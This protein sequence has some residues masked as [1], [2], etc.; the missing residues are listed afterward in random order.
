MLIM[1]LAT[2][3]PNN[4][5]DVDARRDGKSV[6]PIIFT[7]FSVVTISLGRACSTLPPF[8]AAK[9]TQTEPG[10]ITL[11]I[12]S[13]TRIGAFLPGIRAV[14]TMMSTSWACS[15]ISAA[16]A[17][18]KSSDISL[19]YPP[20]PLPSSLIGTSRNV[21]PMDSTCS[22]VTG[23][24][25]KA[26]TIAPIFFAVWMAASPATPAPSTS[27]FAGGTFPAAVICPAKNLGN[28]SAASMIA[29]YPAILACDERTSYV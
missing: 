24:T 28:S 18:L 9:S 2:L 21:A 14:V 7:P 16:C 5:L 12:S 1:N 17:F 6:Y 26:R 4:V 22:F 25:S 23:R 13:L 11:S 27:T 3:F 19:A 10:F 29:L 15:S 8:A 20:E